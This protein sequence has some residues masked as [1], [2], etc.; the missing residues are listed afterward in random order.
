MADGIETVENMG[1][2]MSNHYSGVDFWRS[3]HASYNRWLIRYLYVPMGGNKYKIL[4]TFVIFSFVAL[5]HDMQGELLSWAWLI[6]L[7]IV[8]EIAAV[9][10][11]CTDYV[12][13]SN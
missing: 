1:R 11:F 13:L 12:I 10:L 5:W 4:N 7:F 9:Y 6:A 3:W 2:C 8:P